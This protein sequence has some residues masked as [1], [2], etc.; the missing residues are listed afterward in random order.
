MPSSTGEE[1]ILRIVASISKL[2]DYAIVDLPWSANGDI[3]IYTNQTIPRSDVIVTSH[4][5]S[6][7]ASSEIAINKKTA[8]TIVWCMK[9]GD[10]II[11]GLGVLIYN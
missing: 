7:K 2:T 3:K 4:Q 1:N 10:T 11:I 9:N 5:S 6:N 8:S